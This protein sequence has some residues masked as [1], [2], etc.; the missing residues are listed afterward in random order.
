MRTGNLNSVF[1]RGGERSFAVPG[2]RGRSNKPRFSWNNGRQ[3]AD[4]GQMPNLREGTPALG[5]G[6]HNALK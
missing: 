4:E 2:G 6:G 5:G 1:E 3:E